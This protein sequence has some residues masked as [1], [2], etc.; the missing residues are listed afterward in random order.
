MAITPA[1]R[2]AVTIVIRAEVEAWALPYVIEK[3]THAAPID[4]SMVVTA[5]G[6]PAPIGPTV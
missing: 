6:I 5:D 3:A 4:G 2:V 1:P